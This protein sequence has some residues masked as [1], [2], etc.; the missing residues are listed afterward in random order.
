MKKYVITAAA[1]GLF[2]LAVATHANAGTQDAYPT[3]PDVCGVTVPQLDPTG[4][5]RPAHSPAGEQEVTLPDCLTLDVCIVLPEAPPDPTPTPTPTETPTVSPT[6]PV[7][8]SRAP[9]N[10]VNPI[11]D[12]TGVDEACQLAPLTGG[13]ARTV[14][15]AHTTAF[16]QSIMPLP[17]TQAC[18]E[19]LFGSQAGIPG[20]GSDNTPIMLIAAGLVAAGGLLLLGQR[21]FARR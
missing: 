4:P 14:H 6:P 21:R 2:A 11:L 8:P 5:A 9:H 13:T 16:P 3:V 19:V 10:I 20:T 15:Q 18:Q 17:I 1:V 7:G 12:C